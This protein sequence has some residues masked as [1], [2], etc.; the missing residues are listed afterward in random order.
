MTP[1]DAPNSIWTAD[2]KGQF[3]AVVSTAILAVVDDSY[4]CSPAEI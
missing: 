4:Y 3:A 2:F 1:M